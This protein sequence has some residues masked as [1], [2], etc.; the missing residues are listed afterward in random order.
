MQYA[1]GAGDFI[2]TDPVQILARQELPSVQGVTVTGDSLL[3][4]AYTYVRPQDGAPEGESLF[5]WEVSEDG[6]T[7]WERCV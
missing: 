3:T 5:Q 2:Y 6:E 4:A 7:G 1:G